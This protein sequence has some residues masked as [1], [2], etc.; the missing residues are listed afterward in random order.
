MIWLLIGLAFVAAA[1]LGAS[2]KLLLL[3]ALALALVIVPPL[4][5]GI[6]ALFWVLVGVLLAFTVVESEHRVTIWLIGLGLVAA[7]IIIVDGNRTHIEPMQASP[8]IG[9]PPPRRRRRS[10]TAGPR[11][12]T[13]SV[14]AGQVA[15]GE[16]AA[17]AIEQ[18]RAMPAPAPPLPVADAQTDARQF[19]DLPPHEPETWPFEDQASGGTG[20]NALARAAT[21]RLFRRRRRV[22]PPP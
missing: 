1:L 11:A 4:L 7:L 3:V 6:S 14:G 21:S 18:M 20:I 19:I 5:F 12:A 17:P 16:T 10:P 13:P 2:L 8:Q 22:G 15:P 9:E